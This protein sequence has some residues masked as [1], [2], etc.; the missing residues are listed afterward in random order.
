M[1]MSFD[2]HLF[3]NQRNWLLQIA[4]LTPR[5]SR[6]VARRTAETLLRQRQLLSAVLRY[7]ADVIALFDGNDIIS[8]AENKKSQKKFV[9]KINRP[10]KEQSL[11]ARLCSRSPRPSSLLQ[12]GRARTGL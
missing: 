3:L 7:F 8:T 2:V 4:E 10:Q 6:V 5:R 9:Y 11:E 1:I 12:A